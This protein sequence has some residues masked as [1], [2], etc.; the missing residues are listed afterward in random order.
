MTF[1]KEWIMISENDRLGKYQETIVFGK[2][3]KNTQKGT[4]PME[5]PLFYGDVETS[6]RIL[7]T[8][9]LFAR[10]NLTHLQEIGMLK[11]Q[12]PHTSSRKNLSSYLFFMVLDGSGRLTY[13]GND[14]TLKKGDCVFL[15]CHKPYSHQT[16]E[17]LWTLKWV[18][19]QG[20]NMNGIYEKYAERGGCPRFHCSRPKQYEQLL[21]EIYEIAASASY[22]RDM[23][24]C[25]KLTALLTLLMED[26][27]NPDSQ[28]GSPSRKRDLQ[29]V[30]DYLDLH[31]Q[32]KITLDHLAEQ[33]YIN[34]FYLTRCFREQFG[35]SIGNYLSQVRITHAKRLLRFSDLPIEKIALECGIPDANYFA[36]LFHR[37]EGTAPGEFRKRW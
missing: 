10:S 21:Q 34:K 4:R 12:Q 32:E 35:T 9:S 19:F 3:R 13:N 27:W 8:P 25:E 18:H 15:D 5:T 28:P 30:K 24:I 7:Y 23:K 14:Y 11:A 16:S 20:P 2:T 6:S 1:S 22:V 17:E 29:N 31:F 37:M 33:F 26:G 36:R